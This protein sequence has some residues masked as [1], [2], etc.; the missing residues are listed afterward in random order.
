MNECHIVLDPCHIPNQG[1][2]FPFKGP[3]PIQDPNVSNYL[4]PKLRSPI[5]DFDVGDG[6]ECSNLMGAGRGGN[7]GCDVGTLFESIIPGLWEPT[8]HKGVP[9][10]ENMQNN[11]F[12]SFAVSL[13]RN[14]NGVVFG[15]VKV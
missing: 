14:E 9:L 7:N 1:L 2:V 15:T 8:C 12:F 13:G 5:L 6:T 3:H 10:H 4:T 11:D